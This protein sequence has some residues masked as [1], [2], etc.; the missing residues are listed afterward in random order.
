ME[1]EQYQ[2]PN[3]VQNE[4]F[5]IINEETQ[6]SSHDSMDNFI[7]ESRIKCTDYC[8][9]NIKEVDGETLSRESLIS[10]E[11]QCIKTC[12]TKYINVRELYTKNFE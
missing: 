12:F 1:G 11:K 8:L 4:I 3:K 9:Q 6:Q 10:L 2:E 5:N 7:T